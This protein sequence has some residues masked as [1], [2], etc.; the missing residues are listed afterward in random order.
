MKKIFAI[1]LLLFC[2]LQGVVFAAQAAQQPPL[3]ASIS[4]YINKKDPHLI[5]VDNNNS[6]GIPVDLY[7][8]KML[9]DNRTYA[10]YAKKFSPDQ[11]KVYRITEKII[12]ANNI[13]N[14]NWR[15]GF[16]LAPE[17]I[18]ASASAA[19]LVLITS[20]LYDSLHQND[21]A[22]AFIVSHELAHFLMKH[23]QIMM[24]NSVKIRNMQIEQAVL[25]SVGSESYYLGRMNR[26]NGRSSTV[27]S[28]ASLSCTASALALQ[29]L[30]NRVYAQER[31]LELDADS[32]AVTLMTRAGYNPKKGLEALEFISTIP[33]LYTSRS[34]HPPTAQRISTLSS[35]IGV[36]DIV[37]LKNEG[38]TNIYNSCV[39]KG[40]K[41]MDKR[42]F[43][44]DKPI[45][46][47]HKLVYKPET[48]K[49]KALRFAYSAYKMDNFESAIKWFNQ[50]YQIDK[51]NY[52]PPLYLSY[53]WE[54]KYWKTKNKKCLKQSKKWLK[55]ACKKNKCKDDPV[56]IQQKA[57]IEAIYAK[58][59]SAKTGG[60]ADILQNPNTNIEQPE[61]DFGPYMRSLQRR[62][63]SNWNPPKSD[64]SKH[65]VA[66]FNVNK[67]GEITNIKIVKSSDNITMDAAA[68]DAIKKVSA[69]APL[70]KGFK[71]ND[72]D[73]NFTFDYNVWGKKY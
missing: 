58:I 64:D 36:T 59:E 50:A 23:H 8:K 37:E 3:K 60:A 2:G 43:V 24:E 52:I 46:N 47:K 7:N 10:G 73:I 19:N 48:T 32:E 20:G 49:E 25:G 40:T 39:L 4:A 61:P 1:T 55:I 15:V 57:D 16:D 63:K 42:T 51:K 53:T 29:S 30:I 12:R 67:K 9:C 17:E 70:P 66:V 35:E 72:I 41:S 65:V 14:Q 31:Q 5:I 44:I 62:I 69:Y 38:R 22:I 68:I 54:C 45:N 21:D 18:N 34:T 56:L 11:Y 33:N 28:I 26:I 71:G 13:D 27:D 6:K